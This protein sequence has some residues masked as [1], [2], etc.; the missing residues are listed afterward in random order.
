MTVGI[1]EIQTIS[2]RGDEPGPRML[3]IA[4]VHGDEY[5]PMVA[6][7]RL[8][9]RIRQT[10]VRGEVTLIPV[11]NRP[12]W[13][14]KERV[15]PDGL[16]LAR[17]FPGKADGTPTEQIA[18]AAD[19]LIRQA[20][21]LI[22]MHTGGQRMRLWPLS[23]YLLHPNSAI[24]DQQREMAKAFNLPVVWGTDPTLNGR[25]LSSARDANVPAIYVEYLGAATFCRE[26]VNL[27]VDGC[28]N[29]LN[30]VGML[31]S[32]PLANRVRYWAEDGRPGAGHLQVSQPA[33]HEGSFTAS[34][35]LGEQVEAG[36][37]LGWHYD[38]VSDR[39]SEVIA[40]S[41]GRVVCLAGTKPLPAGYGLAV[42]A[43]FS[44]V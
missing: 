17:T 41:T 7:N 31:D 33:P 35:T 21:F 27:L 6:V 23:G 8:A 26:A 44:A 19:Q 42:I 34:V 14:A 38:A 32:D 25:S 43:E 40:E 18:F 29:T 3:I 1:P 16:D 4:G 9:R 15:G 11:L 30:A 12:A 39:K 13:E 24:L 2:I 20:D 36:Q 22:D 5:E 37:R 28:L 10:T